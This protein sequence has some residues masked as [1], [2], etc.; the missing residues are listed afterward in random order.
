MSN[1][2]HG[3]LIT[4]ILSVLVPIGNCA[5]DRTATQNDEQNK[6]ASFTD[7]HDIDAKEIFEK[8]KTIEN[9]INDIITKFSEI[10][11]MKQSVE[12]L[13][14]QVNSIEQIVKQNQIGIKQM[15]KHTQSAIAVINA[16]NKLGGIFQPVSNLQQTAG[17]NINSIQNRIRA[18]ASNGVTQTQQSVVKN[19]A[20][21]V[22]T[23]MT[24]IKNAGIGA[25]ISKAITSGKNTINSNVVNKIASPKVM[26]NIT[27]TNSLSD[28][29][30]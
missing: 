20:N 16:K 13:K 14:T 2:K 18:I 23:N 19:F 6:I 24:N 5:P 7:T 25:N 9:K 10:K 17:R 3:T 8:L 21:P 1:T 28:L 15:V 30:N 26:N 4:V 12:E 22:T 11:K 27:G 29:L